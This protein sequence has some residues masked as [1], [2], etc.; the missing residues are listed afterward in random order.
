MGK[1]SKYRFNTSNWHNSH[2]FT[3]FAISKQYIS[4]FQM[5]HLFVRSGAALLLC[6][7]ITGCVDKDYDLSNIDTTSEFRVDNLVL[8]INLDA[9]T[10]DKIIDLDEESK[11][12]TVD[13]NGKQFYAVTEEGDFHSEPIFIESF[14][15]TIP[16]VNTTNAIFELNAGGRNASRAASTSKS[17][18]YYDLRDFTPQHVSIKANGIDNSIRAIDELKSKPM[19]ITI[20]LH[21][22]TLPSNVTISMEALKLEMLKG[23]NVTS[24]SAGA[25]YDPQTGILS[26][27]NLNFTNNEAQISLVAEGIDFTLNNTTIKDNSFDCSSEIKLDSGKLKMEVAMSSGQSF[28]PNQRVEFALKTTFS[29]F[30]ATHFSGKIEYKLSGSDLNINP[31][32]LNDIPDFLNQDETDL[33]LA[34]PQIY[35]NLNN[36]VAGYNLYY[37]TGLQLTSIRTSGNKTYAPDNGQKIATAAG[38]SGTLNFVLSPTMPSDPLSQYTKDLKHIPFSGLSNL[39]SGEGLPDEIEI[40]LINPELPLQ[41]VAD[42]KLDNNIEGV[43]GNYYFLAPLALKTESTIIYTDSKDGWNDEDLDKLKITSLELEA[44]ATSTIPLEATIVAYPLDKHGNR[45][46]GV[47]ATGK[48]PANCTDEHIVITMEGTIEHLDGVTF[49]ATVH[50]GDENPLAPSQTIILKNLRARVSGSYLTDF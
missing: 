23:L 48:L 35:L 18:F 22:S 46:S 43:K 31:I 14:T 36:P 17:V 7:L 30:I 24:A 11:I 4:L 13:I 44:D 41:T 32:T 38:N 25:K 34:N 50:P 6:A 33:I 45:I 5:K 42:F 3:Y 37:Q 2:F 16:P 20:A 9:I 10:L 28:T 26:I 47:K 19:T 29:P 39:L 40:D 12:K 1:W 27:E 21:E 49:E 15:A 8:P